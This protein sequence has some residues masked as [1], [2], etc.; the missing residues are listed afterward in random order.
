VKPIVSGAIAALVLS[1]TAFAQENR[2]PAISITIQE[3][4]NRF[5]DAAIRRL[6]AMELGATIVDSPIGATTCLV[7]CEGDL[8]Y[9]RVE[10]PTT[11]KTVTRSV[12]VPVAANGAQPRMVALALAELAIAS[13][14]ELAS[15]P[16][17]SVPSAESPSPPEARAAAL[18][19]VRTRATS[20]LIFSAEASSRHFFLSPGM[21]WGVA[22]R[23]ATQRP[24]SGWTLGVDLMAEHQ[25]TPDALG[26]VVAY[27]GSLA[28]DGQYQ[29]T[30]GFLRLSLG[31][32]FRLGLAYLAGEPKDST[33]QPGNG[34]DPW[35]GPAIVAAAEAMTPWQVSARLGV[36]AGYTWL[37]IRS[38]VEG[39][40]S[41]AMYGPWLGV[42][43]GIGYAP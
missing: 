3:C 17:P 8:V 37:S 42:T 6:T 24:T 39:Q 9:L 40:D 11:A 28:V 25:Q 12:R 20:G 21:L 18:E 26:T 16:H 19:A 38:Q 5:D 23:A 14:T 34:T 43:L 4:T 35:G 33:V 29:A 32:A 7:V 27:S 10:D 22:V 15:N 13:W 1:A 30:M 31:A 2:R 36:E 41:V